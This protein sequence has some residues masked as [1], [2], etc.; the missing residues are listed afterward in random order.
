L[1]SKRER[2][3]V[4]I[5]EQYRAFGGNL[6]DTADIYGDGE[7]E[8]ALGLYFR[9]HGR[10]EDVVIVTKGCA[11]SRLV[12]PECLRLAIDKSL[13]RLRTDYIDLYLLHR[14]DPQV[15]VGELVDALNEAAR[16]GKIR[17]FG[18]S[19][20]TTA[21]LEAANSYARESQSTGFTVS[22]PHLAL[23]TPREPWWP[24]CT[25]VTSEDLE[26]YAKTA[27]PVL[28]W[29][30]Q[31][32][33]FFS[34]RAVGDMAYMAELVRVYYT[35]ENLARR[36]RLKKLAAIRGIDA[37]ALAVAYVAS[38]PITTVALVGLRSLEELSCVMTVADVQLS[39]SEMACGR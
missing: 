17:A 26:Y 13:E 3:N 16:A 29:S 31:C 28:A 20:W 19:N 35:T 37:S 38:L 1:H 9:S 8:R 27:M 34:N 15:P 2:E 4:I 24:G 25:H 5:L 21:R 18:G 11:E 14:D 30:T 23:A 33:G 10:R 36:E 39:A 12:R 7:S 22:S 6:F 32:R